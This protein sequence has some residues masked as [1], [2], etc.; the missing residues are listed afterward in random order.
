MNKN[1]NQNKM[2]T[3]VVLALVV[4]LSLVFTSC[5]EFG[6][7]ITP[8]GNVT[9]EDRTVTG[10]SG[11]DVSHAFN[12]YVNFSDTEESIVVEANENLQQYIICEVRNGKLTIKL[13][14]RI[15]VKW[16][17]STM[18]VYITTKYLNEFDASGASNIYL[19][20]P[21][22]VDDLSVDLSGASNFE[23]EV[24][25]SDMVADISGASNLILTGT[26]DY[27]RMDVSGASTVEEYD[28]VTNWFDAD[29]S[30]ASN[31]YVTINDRIDLEASGASTLNYMGE[32]TINTIN[33]SGASNIKR[34]Y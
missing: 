22:I 3:K 5:E 12:A 13:Q 34:V 11:L 27:A 23:G 14:D 24:Y 6:D 31:A 2:K 21:L 30:G 17:Q 26:A 7:W 10:Y 32:G 16:G 1:Q 4:G 29:L 15:F 18:N 20:D 28:F 9:Q 19:E 33:L 8:S 25:V